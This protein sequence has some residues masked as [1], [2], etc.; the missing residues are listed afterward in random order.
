[1]NRSLARVLVIAKACHP[2][3]CLAVSSFAGMFAYGSGLPLDRCFWIFLAV[4]FHQ[5]SV[6][7]SNDWLDFE[8][9]VAA[10]RVDKPTVTGLLSVSLLRAL[11][12]ASALT[13]I[14]L[15]F[16]LG[17]GATWLMIFM[18]IVGWGYNLGMKSNWT[19]FIP[20]AVGFGAVPVF[21]GVAA[22]EPFFA[23]VWTIL[24]AALLGVSAHFA[25]VSPDRI[26]DKLTGVNALPHILGQRVS[27]L[28]IA[29]SALLATVI[30]VTQSANLASG[31]AITGLVLVIPLVI[32][33][34]LLSL[35]AK[36]PRLVFPLLMLAA[37]VNVL[38]LMF[39]AGRI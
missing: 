22:T 28:V 1:M 35:K 38:L 31:L 12:I 13:A 37:L 9:D 32:L 14:T 10:K 21:V 24:V 2:I 17:P 26:A 6:G 16:G 20:Y 25:N 11:A 5:F 18:L 8:K 23:P 3:P 33:A 36:P 7:F 30:V 29:S 34:S 39:G 27:A 19:S 4:L 15:T